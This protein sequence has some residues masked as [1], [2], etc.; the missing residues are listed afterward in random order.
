MI[1]NK[2]KASFQ[3]SLMLNVCELMP[4]NASSNLYANH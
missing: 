1:V 3:K 4:P 2:Y